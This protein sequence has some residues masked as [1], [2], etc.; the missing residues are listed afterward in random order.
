MGNSSSHLFVKLFTEAHNNTMKEIEEIRKGKVEPGKVPNKAAAH[1]ELKRQTSHWDEENKKVLAKIFEK[2]DA[3]SD[4][5]LDLKEC[6][7]LTTAALK[8][9]MKISPKMI[10]KV[11]IQVCNVRLWVCIR[12]VVVVCGVYQ[13]VES[14]TL[15]CLA[16]LGIKKTKLVTQS[17]TNATKK[18]KKRASVIFEHLMKDVNRL[19]TSLWKIMDENKDNQVTRDEFM[20][21]YLSASLKLINMDTLIKLSTA[22]QSTKHIHGF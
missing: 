4:G 22:S 9:H 7:K 2:F 3:N 13:A 14:H 8:A 5:F 1:K 6:T 20:R 11:R 15:S 16:N 18:A 21:N 17:I 10:A 12:W 19:A